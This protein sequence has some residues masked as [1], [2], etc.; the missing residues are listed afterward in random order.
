MDQ[1]KIFVGNLPFNTSPEKVVEVFSEFGKIVDS[2]VPPRK[3]YAFI[4]FENKEAMKKAIE[5]MNGKDLDGR[6][7]T[8]SVAKP[9][10]DK[11][12]RSS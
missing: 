1:N 6:A 8:V 12:R 5:K 3:G 9:R 10:T 4:T 2:Y 11:P 7:L